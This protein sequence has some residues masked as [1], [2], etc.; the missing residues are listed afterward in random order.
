MIAVVVVFCLTQQKRIRKKW[1]PKVANTTH[2]YPWSVS[3]TNVP[4][5]G[6]STRYDYDP[7]VPN[8]EIENNENNSETSSGFSEPTTP[9]GYS[10]NIANFNHQVP[11]SRIGRV[12]SNVSI[13]LLPRSSVASDVSLEDHNYFSLPWQP[14]SQ[15]AVPVPIRPMSHSPVRRSSVESGC[16]RPAAETSGY[17]TSGYANEST[18]NMPTPTETSISADPSPLPPSKNSVVD[19][20][21]EE[22]SK[23]VPV[24]T[25]DKSLDPELLKLFRSSPPLLKKHEYWV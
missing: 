15:V 1:Q 2:P 22:R 24:A 23:A 13:T 20:R 7:T 16:L 10:P 12:H 3:P 4:R 8:S 17:E 6:I 9:V 5:P 11:R 18:R 19:T 14:P 25:S 21:N